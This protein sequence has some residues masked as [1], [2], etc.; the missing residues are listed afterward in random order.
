MFDAGGLNNLR[1][2]E[3]AVAAVP[4]FRFGG[5]VWLDDERVGVSRSFADFERLL[6]FGCGCGRMLRHL[7]EL[8]D[9]VEI[10]G[11][12]LD[13]EMIDWLRSNVTYGSYEVASPE[14][15]LPY[16]EHFFEALDG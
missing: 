6:D 5:E 2:F 7:G 1:L 9:R 11:T 4:R 8:A 14:P 13:A 10:H 16:P 3:H 15:P 12:D